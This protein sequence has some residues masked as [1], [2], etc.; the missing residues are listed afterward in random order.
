MTYF[1]AHITPQTVEFFKKNLNA[2][3]NF[4]KVNS[5]IKEVSGINYFFSNQEESSE[6]LK[7][8]KE[9]NSIVSKP[10]RREYGDFQT[11][12][13]LSE[14]VSKYVLLKRNDFEFLLEPTCGKGN[15]I[16]ASIKTFKSL[17]KIVGVEIYKPYVW[18][19]KFKI[20]DYFITVL[21]AQKE[22]NRIGVVVNV[23]NGQPSVPQTEV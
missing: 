15:F 20:L 19:T 12:N 5:L 7:N 9:F 17:K 13:E 1:E 6:L 2:L 21:Y 14:L 11:N 4:E 23:T 18:E 10:H 22:Y 3:S 16:L 8:I